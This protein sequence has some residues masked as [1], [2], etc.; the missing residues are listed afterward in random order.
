MSDVEDIRDRLK[1]AIGA[2]NRSPSVQTMSDVR[3]MNTCAN[4]RAEISTLRARVR[5]LEEGLREIDNAPDPDHWV[6]QFQHVRDIARALLKAR[7][8]G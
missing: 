2:L 1:A 8:D 6:P 7:T 4:A 3:I 5:E